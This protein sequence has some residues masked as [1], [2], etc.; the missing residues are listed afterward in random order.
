MTFEI[1]F[2]KYEIHTFTITKI[3]LAIAIQN[4]SYKFII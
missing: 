3:L 2:I 4:K 1:K